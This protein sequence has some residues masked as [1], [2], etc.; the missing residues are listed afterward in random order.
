MTR[1]VWA[2]VGAVFALGCAGA[3]APIVFLHYPVAGRCAAELAYNG[4]D[5]AWEATVVPGSCTA[6]YG[7]EDCLSSHVGSADTLGCSPDGMVAVVDEGALL[8]V[9]T[10]SY[11]VDASPTYARGAA[12]CVAVVTCGREGATC[13]VTVLPDTCAAPYGHDHCLLGRVDFEPEG[14]YADV[15]GCDPTG[16]RAEIEWEVTP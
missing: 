6:P 12:T 3:P 8:R 10:L 16:A 5:E 13:A 15:L 1:V 7:L 4:R 14:D 11:P 2:A 9:T